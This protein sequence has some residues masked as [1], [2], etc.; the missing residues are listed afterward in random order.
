MEEADED[1]Q[2]SD[3]ASIK[4][5]KLDQSNDLGNIKS[6]EMSGSLRN[7]NKL[8]T[9]NFKDRK[10]VKNRYSIKFAAV[11]ENSNMQ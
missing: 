3:K 4:L 11:E 8:A 7:K 10:I 1:D 2:E 6:N 5:E 9:A